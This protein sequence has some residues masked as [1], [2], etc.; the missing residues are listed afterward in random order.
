MY[1]FSWDVPRQEV[2]QQQPDL[3]VYPGPFPIEASDLR[4]RRKRIV[5]RELGESYGNG[6][7]A[8]P[9]ITVDCACDCRLKT[10]HP[11]AVR[12]ARR[13]VQNTVSNTA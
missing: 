7:P 13:A 10:G 8:V 1:R 3:F 11:M 2:Q 5:A 6:S 12:V 4:P 9:G